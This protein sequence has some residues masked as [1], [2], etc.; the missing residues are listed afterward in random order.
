MLQIYNSL[1]RKKEPFTPIEDNHVR[2]YVCGMTV[3][4]YCHIGHAVRSL[5]LMWWHVISVQRLCMTY[6]RN[7]TDVMTRL[8][9][10][11]LKVVNTF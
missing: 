10:V 2:M 1:S 7:V 5:H 11:L 9:N 4:D 3:Y 8:L 6:V